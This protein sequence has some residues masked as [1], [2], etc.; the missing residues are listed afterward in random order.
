MDDIVV[1]TIEA[2][3]NFL[4]QFMQDRFRLGDVDMNRFLVQSLRETTSALQSRGIDYAALRWALTP[5]AN[6]QELALLFDL[7]QVA[8]AWYGRAIHGRIIPLLGRNGS[9]SILDGDLL[10]DQSW[11]ASLLSIHL[12][13]RPLRRPTHGTSV[14]CVYVNN[15][16]PAM[17]QSVQ[18]GLRGFAPF[19]GCAD[20]T[21]SSDFK[22][23]LSLVL[24][25]SYVQHGRLII[26]AHP[27]DAAV[28][29]NENTHGYP[30]ATS[31]Y[32]LRSVPEMYFDPFLSYK[33]ERP[34]LVSDERDR[35]MSLNAVSSAPGDV[36][37]W[38]I[39]IEPGRLG[40]LER[41][42]GY[43]LERL[44]I[45]GKPA[46]TL[47][48]MIRAKLAS[49]YLYNLRYRPDFQVVSFNMLL[50]LESHETGE[51]FRAVAAFKYDHPRRAIQLLTLF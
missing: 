24:G 44:G 15:C 29:A 6:R 41:E 45:L 42:K 32:D 40:Y 14:Y 21:Y 33:I 17:A 12:P 31:G 2:R 38:D 36:T 18:D 4:L 50:E 39:E 19:L 10:G 34:V 51:S 25:V 49:T 35:R 30:F 3:D 13:D 7:G 9:R 20:M 23:Y 22:T 27:D 16:T 47:V 5:R 1:H 46:V 48:E 28:D 37:D 11:L 8:D 26:Q 43:A